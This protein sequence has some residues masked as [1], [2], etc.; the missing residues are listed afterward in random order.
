MLLK[1]E[2]IGVHLA[3][4]LQARIDR[5]GLEVI[6]GGTASEAYYLAEGADK[7]IVV[8]AVKAGFEAGAVYRLRPEDLAEGEA[9]LS[10]HEL[11]L[12]HGLRNMEH[13]GTRPMDVV[14]IGVEPKEIGWGLELSPE[15]EQ[16]MPQIIEIVLAEAGLKL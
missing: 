6:D 16:R 2:G 1:D 8:D 12:L 7:L 3:Q 14:I 5:A 13:R 11:G 15:L 10:I 9:P 4:S